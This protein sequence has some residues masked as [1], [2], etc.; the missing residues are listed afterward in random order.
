[1]HASPSPLELLSVPGEPVVVVERAR[2]PS[3]LLSSIAT[4]PWLTVVSAS[5][6]GHADR[7]RPRGSRFLHGEITFVGSLEGETA[8]AF[9][10]LLRALATGEIEFAAPS[11]P[12]RLAGL[13]RNRGLGV[14]V[15]RTCAWCPGVVAAVLRLALATPRLDVAVARHDDPAVVR[16]VEVVPAVVLDGEVV[17]RGAI[18]ERALV[19]L[20]LERR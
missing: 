6:T 13:S 4:V 15:T 20:L 18:D 2:S 10:V 12:Q 9:V 3:L 17:A 1:M 14:H 16:R 11:T 8:E 7:T 5:A 19:D